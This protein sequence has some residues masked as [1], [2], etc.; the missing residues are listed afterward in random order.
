V[1][2]EEGKGVGASALGAWAGEAIRCSDLDN[3]SILDEC[4]CTC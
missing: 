4:E 1:Q 3:E 2:A